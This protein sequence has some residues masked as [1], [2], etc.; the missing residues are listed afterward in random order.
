MTPADVLRAYWRVALL[1]ACAVAVAGAVVGWAAGG[2]GAAV[3]VAA[4]TGGGAVVGAYL[5][6]P[7]SV[8][9][10][11]AALEESRARGYAEGL[12]HGML[13][14]VA[15]YEAAVFPKTPGGVRPEERLARRADAYR[16]AS[17]DA[18]PRA[19][20][21]A[22]AAALEALDGGDL[23][24]SQDAVGKLFTAVHEQTAGR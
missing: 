17:A 2:W 12:S 13:S 22:A 14:A 8:A 1:I 18:L 21:V 23:S 6:R 9:E 16:M 19:V 5:S 20:R 11:T 24:A 3:V 7:H 4:M 10:A 15:V